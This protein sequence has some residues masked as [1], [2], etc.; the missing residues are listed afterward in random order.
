MTNRKL[1]LR[2]VPLLLVLLVALCL[3]LTVLRLAPQNSSQNRTEELPDNSNQSRE[4]IIGVEYVV[5]GIGEGFA[6][7][8][9]PAVKPLPE[10]FSWD[11]MQKGPDA[12]IDFTITDRYVREF[13]S[14]GF[15]QIVLAL[16]PWAGILM[17]PWMVDETYPQT[18]AVAP[19][20]HAQYSN[21]V[22]SLVERY[23]MDGRDDMPE[24][25]T[26][27]STTRSASSSL[28]TSPSPRRS[29]YRPLSWDTR[30]PM[31]PTTTFWL[32]IPPS[33]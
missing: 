15:T 25:R 18:Q 8:G 33:W 7:L 6:D 16:R 2:W 26:L 10:I 27:S 29:T 19:A 24:L 20:Y 9:I 17:K 21:W 22:R 14:N 32:G 30:L 13:Q 23:D 12:P 11:K 4:L 5:Y 31:R 1:V 28:P 3:V